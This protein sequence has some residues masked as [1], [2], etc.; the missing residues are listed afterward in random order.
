MQGGSKFPSAGLSRERLFPLA[1]KLFILIGQERK[2]KIIFC[3]FM[4][5]IGKWM[6][7]LQNPEV[8]TGSSSLFL[9]PS[10]PVHVSRGCD[11]LL[12]RAQHH[13]AFPPISGSHSETGRELQVPCL[14]HGDYSAGWLYRDNVWEGDGNEG[15][16][17][18]QIFG[19]NSWKKSLRPWGQLPGNAWKRCAKKQPNLRCKELPFFIFLTSNSKHLLGSLM[20]VFPAFC[21][22]SLLCVLFILDP[23]F[24]QSRDHVWLM[25]VSNHMSFPNAQDLDEGR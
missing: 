4:L 5:E 8:F 1:L 12:L 21:H 20:S 9:C 16:K 13:A 18:E 14:I 2:I 15:D 19:I 3:V 17:S 23:K 11:W 6:E 10:L 7:V 25:A 24:L 22:L